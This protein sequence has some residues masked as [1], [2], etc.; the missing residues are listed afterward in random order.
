MTIP[1]WTYQEA[2]DILSHKHEVIKSYSFSLSRS[3]WQRWQND[4]LI[5]TEN[6]QPHTFEHSDTHFNSERTYR[7]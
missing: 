7:T 3:L 5:N 2:R 1:N 6:N 4:T